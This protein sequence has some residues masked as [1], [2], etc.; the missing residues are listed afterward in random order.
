MHK[1]LAE[2]LTL[3]EGERLKVYRCPAGKL[4]IGVGRNLEDLGI[5]EEESEYL[6]DNDI[7]RVESELDRE[8]SWWRT[9][10]DVRQAVLADMNF[11]LGIS[12]FR[13]FKKMLAALEAGNWPEAAV[14]M[15]RSKWA[16]DVKQRADRLIRMMETDQWPE[17]IE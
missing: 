14:Q 8:F 11:N 5:T 2:L 17:E 7:R 12:R 6:L 15:R 1:R 13:R 4:S 3:D 9:L 16:T 10:S